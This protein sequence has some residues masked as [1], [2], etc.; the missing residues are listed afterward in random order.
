[1]IATGVV[2]LVSTISCFK[3]AD[4][5]AQKSYISPPKNTASLS[6]QE[7]TVSYIGRSLIKST[8]YSALF[9]SPLHNAFEFADIQRG[10]Q[11]TLSFDIAENCS[12]KTYSC[13][14]AK[15][16]IAPLV[17][18]N[19][20]IRKLDI[21]SIHAAVAIQDLGRGCAHYHVAELRGD[22]PKSVDYDYCPD[23]GVFHIVIHP[24]PSSPG[25]IYDLTSRT[26]LM[27]RS[28]N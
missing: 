22:F 4:R 11:Q 26:G 13:F 2:C 14:Y 16:Y 25:Q 24:T 12:T 15:G 3:P 5:R 21:S 18:A 17:L 8:G 20:G 19:G 28:A 10:F 6:P 7:F 23:T 1:M 9:L 27:F